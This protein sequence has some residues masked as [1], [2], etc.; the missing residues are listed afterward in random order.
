MTG[1]RGLAEYG[2]ALLHEYRNCFPKRSMHYPFETN[3]HTECRRATRIARPVRE[4]HL[5]HLDPEKE[6]VKSLAQP[7]PSI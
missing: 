3:A 4:H 7:L 6:R 1:E 2:T 5:E